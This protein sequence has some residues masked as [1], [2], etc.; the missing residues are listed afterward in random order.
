MKTIY[1]KKSK[2]N[3]SLI[4][5]LFALSFLVGEGSAL[6]VSECV[7]TFRISNEVSDWGLGFGESGTECKPTGNVSS[8]ELAD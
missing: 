4:I 6:M 8:E 7:E 3:F 1:L 2:K 5:F